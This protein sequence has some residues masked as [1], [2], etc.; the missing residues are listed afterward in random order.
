MR[1]FHP[2]CVGLSNIPREPFH[3]TRCEE[4]FEREGLCDVTLD[5]ELMQFVYYGKAPVSVAGL[6]RCS[7]MSKWLKVTGMGDLEVIDE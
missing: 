3:C 2:A 7:G 5:K 1:A 6:E 4:R